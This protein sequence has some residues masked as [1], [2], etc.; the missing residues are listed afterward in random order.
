MTA[1]AP[2]ALREHKEA[3]SKL[4]RK[5]QEQPCGHC[6]CVR[7][8]HMRGVGKCLNTCECTEFDSRGEPPADLSDYVPSSGPTHADEHSRSLCPICNPED[9]DV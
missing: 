3:I 1:L 4:S 7:R 5:E 6:E 9:I 8:S 2:A